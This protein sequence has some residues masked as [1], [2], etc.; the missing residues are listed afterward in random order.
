MQESD[1][2]KNVVPNAPTQLPTVPM[3]APPVPVPDA[4]APA[5]VVPPLPPIPAGPASTPGSAPTAPAAPATPATVQAAPSAE[6]VIPATAPVLTREQMS[7]RS[8]VRRSTASITAKKSATSTQDERTPL[9]S[10][11]QVGDYV[12]KE[13]IGIGGF[14]IVYSATNVKDGSDVAIKEHMPEG[15]A[16]REPGGFYVIHSTPESEERFK[17]S[18]NEFLQEVSVLMGISHPGIVPILSAFEA[19]GTAYYVM[20]FMK[21]EALSVPAQASLSFDLQSQEARHNRRLLL[22]MLSIL[23]YLRMHNIV[24]RDIKPD[25]ILIT[26]EGNPVLLDFGSARQLQEGKVFTNVFTP[27]FAAPEQAQAEN[28]EEMSANIGPWT[29]IYA[30]G[31][32]FYYMVTRLYPPRAELRVLSGE[33]ADPYTPLADRSDLEILYGSAF[34]RAIDRALS[35]R[36]EDRWQTAAAW[37]IA[38]GE[39]TVTQPEEKKKRFGLT[40]LLPLGVLAIL[41]G[42]SFWALW[43]R[44]AAIR[45]YDN[46]AQ[47]TERLL[48][49][50]NQEIADIPASTRLQGILGDHLNSYLNNMGRPP[51]GRDEKLTLS[52]AASWRNLGVLRLQ[53]GLLSEADTD[54]RNAE[55]YFRQLCNEHSSKINYQFDLAGVLLNRIEVARSRNQSKT[56][57]D[58]LWEAMQIL[59]HIC[60]RVP[61]NPEFRCALGQA[62][63]EQALLAHSEGNTQLYKSSLESML[64]LYRDLLST[65]SDHVKARQ[66]LG[67]A[68]V[69]NAQFAMG[70]NDIAA[71]D[72]LLDEAKR[73]FTDLSNQHPYRLSF[74]KGLSLTLYNLGRL[75]SRAG[76][77]ASPEKRS[78]YDERA[79]EAYRKHNDIVRYLETQD[80]KKTE[81]PYMYCQALSNMVDILLRND[82]PNLA[83][84]YSRTIMRKMEKLRKNAPDNVDYAMLEA[85]A[86]RGM[87]LA[88]SRSPYFSQKADEEFT[89]YRRLAEKLLQQSPA[90][91]TLQFIYTD[92]LMESANLALSQGNPQQAIKWYS[93]AQDLLEKLIQTDPH[94][95]DYKE[96]LELIKG[97]LQKA[98]ETKKS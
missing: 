77:N 4:V 21:G 29:D 97:L 68:L 93:H 79:L 10:G 37:K 9:P 31:A 48:Y 76:E 7:S 53:Q 33:G 73:V 43:E 90:N 63:C 50:F 65:F 35:L 75:Y 88:H 27:D 56:Q 87:G 92:A 72:K 41:G 14:G 23:D 81:Y 98:K 83:E 71:A 61:Y 24:H 96:R 28:D 12:I 55:G 47:F 1:L 80:E 67:Y 6:P 46:S 38:I 85:A 32:C 20:P 91:T 62:L 52:L 82:Q 5:P 60:Q 15:L 69:Y 94:Q 26:P 54:L 74:K 16:A 58:L 45:A 39:G 19:N 3:E 25:N 18:V 34:L 59:E 51:G 17:A 36:R 86:W 66:W 70:Q 40:S 44:R 22:S 30:L 57:T 84:A 64:A 11:T 78:F 42:I 49:D 89:N 13:K 95:S 8:R 2:N